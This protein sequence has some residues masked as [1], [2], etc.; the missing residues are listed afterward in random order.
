VEKICIA[1]LR[2]RR[3]YSGDSGEG[4]GQENR[5]GQERRLTGDPCEAYDGS[6]SA[7]R[8]ADAAGRTVSLLLTQEQM[9]TLQSNRHLASL[10]SGERAEGF[11]AMQ[12]RDE[13]IVIKIEFESIPPVRLLKMDEV[14]GMLRISRT[15]LNRIVRQG[16]LTSYK[17]GRLRRI[18]LADILSYLEDHLA[19][20]L[21]REQASESTLSSNTMPM[22]QSRIKEE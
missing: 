22:Q 5:A 17:F 15:S 12:N 3:A 14:C 13:P 16:M 18:M 2:K 4:F 1:K 11:A 7:S 10:L 21:A 20:T 9:K 6:G 19:V 8:R